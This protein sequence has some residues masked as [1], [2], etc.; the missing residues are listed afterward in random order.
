MKKTI[1]AGAVLMV[2]LSE[3]VAMEI[4][5]ECETNGCF[6]QSTYSSLATNLHNHRENPE[7]T[8]HP[9]VAAPAISGNV[10]PGSV[11]YFADAVV[12][13]PQSTS[14]ALDA[15]VALPVRA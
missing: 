7:S 11:S 1:C 12:A 2:I 6:M 13:V 3:P 14:F 5:P 8:S 10:A 9:S 15:Y 4:A